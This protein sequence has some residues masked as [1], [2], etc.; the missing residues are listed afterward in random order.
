MDK[1]QPQNKRKQVADGADDN[2]SSSGGMAGKRARK[3]VTI[4]TQEVEVACGTVAAAAEPTGSPHNKRKRESSS[5]SGDNKDTPQQDD[6]KVAPQPSPTKKQK[7]DD[8]VAAAVAATA[9]AAVAAQTAAAATVI[10]KE[11]QNDAE[12]L[13][14][15]Y[16]NPDPR[17]NLRPVPLHGTA[18]Y[19]GRTA[20]LPCKLPSSN[21]DSYKKKRDSETYKLPNS[22]SDHRRAARQGGSTYHEFVAAV[23]PNSAL[24]PPTLRGQPC[25][26]VTSMVAEE[27]IEATTPFLTDGPQTPARL[28]QRDSILRRD[29]CIA[30]ELWGEL[31]ALLLEEHSLRLSQSDSEQPV[32]GGGLAVVVPKPHITF[33]IVEKTKDIEAQLHSLLHQALWGCEAARWFSLAAHWGLGPDSWPVLKRCAFHLLCYRFPRLSMK[34]LFGR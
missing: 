22:S 29:L 30:T 15:P 8:D 3:S 31:L 26:D 10:S 11:V 28:V 24:F 23:D 16:F 18:V 6:E 13:R 17:P 20:K 9:A 32:G 4:E 5:S 25:L 34:E 1:P 12:V 14:V 7:H 27:K 21:S 33:L 19:I 2:S